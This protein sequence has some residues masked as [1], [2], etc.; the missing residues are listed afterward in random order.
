MGNLSI[1]DVFD[2][3]L[4]A[5][6]QNHN[7]NSYHLG[8]I[9]SIQKCRTKHMGGHWKVCT[10]CGET[11]K[12]YNSCG[13]RHCPTCQG[14]NKEKW[15]LN[16]EY[17]LLPIKYF[18][19]VFTVPSELRVLFIYNQ[20]LLYN[21]LF[22]TAW[23]TI[24]E[25]AHDPRQRMMAK[26]GMIAILHTWTQILLY[27]P[28]LHCIVPAG[29]IDARQQWKKSKGNSDFLFYTPN[30]ARKFRGKFLF[31][32]HEL[33]KTNQLYL[34]GK[35]DLYKHKK[36]WYNLKDRLYNTNWVVDCKEPFK[37]PET[38]LE[39]LGRYTHKIA[40]S[41]YRIK[42]ITATHVGFTYLDRKDGNKKK[43]LEIPG[44]KFIHRFLCHIVPYRFVRIRHYGFLSTRL[45]KKCLQTIR[46]TLKAKTPK[47]PGKLLCRDVIL[48]VYGKDIN[49]CP[50][51][52]RGVLLTYGHWTKNKEPPAQHR[53][54]A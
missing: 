14:I 13:N 47:K 1:A 24:N 28:H 50:T 2:K 30:V 49:I 5:Y 26:T 48:L 46:T 44:E 31:Y 51:C 34:N 54:V 10:H 15:I 18:H 7:M 21:V 33:Y 23:Q 40:I 16:R 41:N 27:H 45:K 43:Y 53:I 36:H 25:F 37:G 52:K 19:V 39:Y 17:D 4:P 9:D 12:H 42:K 6:Q 35:A 3:F 38:V 11:K 22:K 20:K 29:G 8:V 32:L